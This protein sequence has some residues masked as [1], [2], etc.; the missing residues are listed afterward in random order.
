MEN[1]IFDLDGTLLD[2]SVGVK[3]ALINT[4]R[5]LKYYNWKEGESE[6]KSVNT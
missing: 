5:N 6:K 3:K 2:T 4:L 1:I